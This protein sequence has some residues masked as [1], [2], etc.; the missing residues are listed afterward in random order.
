MEMTIGAIE[1]YHKDKTMNFWNF[2]QKFKGWAEV[3][4]AILKA[5]AKNNLIDK[6]IVKDAEKR[7][8]SL[9][10]SKNIKETV[11]K[12]V[13]R[14]DLIH[15][16][17]KAFV[18]IVSEQALTNEQAK[19]FHTGVTSYDTEDTHL[20][21][22][23]QKSTLII[24]DNLELLSLILRI[25]SETYKNQSQVF[26]THGV[27]AEPGTFGLKLL[28]FYDETIRHTVEGLEIF[29]KVSVGKISG[30]VGTYRGISPLVEKDALNLLK[31]K[32][33]NTST[34]IISRDIHATYLAWLA[35]IAGSLEKFATEIRNL[36]RTEILEVEEHFRKKQVGSSTMVHKRNP[37]RSENIC[38]LARLVR[39]FSIVSFEN[40]VTWHERDLTNSGNERFI[41]PYASILTNHIIKKFTK[42]MEK[43][44]VY[45][46]NM[47]RNLEKTREFTASE[48]VMIAMTKKGM[49]R[50]KAYKIVQDNARSAWEK[51]TSFKENLLKDKEIK[52]LLSKKEVEECL[53]T[54]KHLDYIDTIFDRVDKSLEKIAKDI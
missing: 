4:I 15:H 19:H 44:N 35:K 43:L 52:K 13:K 1:R 9:F 22:N 18:E 23:M 2:D 29:E 49:P 3:E 47:E 17:M 39:S 14:D 42:V 30:A 10:N 12:I 28:N 38:S 6:K 8:K 32:V 48:E 54:E 7:V 53:E 16:D 25:L 31:L 36:Q 21:M 24:V 11:N 46:K 40:Q 50:E 41:L 45:P 51:G 26:R 27:H 34:Q 33:A 20:A 5:K 37:I